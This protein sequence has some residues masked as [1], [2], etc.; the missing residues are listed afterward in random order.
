[1]KKVTFLLLSL[2]FVLAS[3]S[4]VTTTN[5]YLIGN[6]TTAAWNN[7]A[8]LQMTA[9]GDGTFTWT[10]TLQ[11]KDVVEA[12]KTR[13]KFLIDGKN[14]SPCILANPNTAQ[15][16]Y[17]MLTSGVETD[18]Y[19]WTGSPG[20]D[21]A[22]VV[23]ETAEYTIGINLNTMKMT[24]TKEI[25]VTPPLTENLYITGEATT[26]G[27]N[28]TG[29]I[30]MTKVSADVFTWTGEL[31]GKDDADAGKNRFTFLID[32]KNWYP[33]IVSTPTPVQEHFVLTS[34]V[35]TD[36]FKYI[37]GGDAANGGKE[38]TFKVAK[39]GDYK[40][41]INLIT[42]KMTCTQI[43]PNPNQL[44]L[45]GDATSAG[46]DSGKMLPMIKVGSG[47]FTWTGNL[48]EGKQFKFAN[49][50]GTFAENV[51]PAGSANFN[52]AT[53]TDYPLTFKKSDWKFIVPSGAGGEYT[54]KVDL[55]QMKA[56]IIAG[57]DPDNLI[58]LEQL[59]LIGNA[60]TAGW[61]NAN[62]IPMT[63]TSEGIFT[64]TGDLSAGQFKF[65]NVLA[66]WSNT[67]NPKD[68]NDLEFALDT[69]YDLKY[70]PYEGSPNDHKFKVTTAGAYKIDVNLN[71]MKVNITNSTGIKNTVVIP[72][73]VKIENGSVNVIAEDNNNIQSVNLFD[74]SGK[75][76]SGNNLPKGVY[77][78]KVK[79]DG[80]KYIRKIMM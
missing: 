22:F 56:R 40:I 79:Y 51:N 68:A 58:S 17:F 70:R 49:T 54:I 36:V 18:I 50:A 64:W 53:D 74:I 66:T 62:A 42:M 73:E 47:I 71:T 37:T 32:G 14:W 57:P 39:T 55:I 41:D 16:E 63:K 5:L 26:V 44:Y 38:N 11:G 29:A 80:K 12:G 76:I 35:E 52:F 15:L 78:L 43:L 1:M 8:A 25:P 10:G 4:A 34:G 3:S 72:F 21:N 65:L 67:V 60:T 23:A 24:C 33:R 20:F 28:N 7:G 13:F 6:A 9:N 77:I 61:E 30:L 48:A 19:E 75:S 27:W 45:C 2:F 69:D 59:Y 31:K 46:W